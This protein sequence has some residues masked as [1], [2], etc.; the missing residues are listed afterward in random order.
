MTRIWRDWVIISFYGSRK[1]H[2]DNKAANAVPTLCLI[3]LQLNISDNY[4]HAHMHQA[5]NSYRELK[6]A[7]RVVTD[8][9]NDIL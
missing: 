4:N 6:T 5:T 8:N 3:R 1:G 2:I 9:F 7:K